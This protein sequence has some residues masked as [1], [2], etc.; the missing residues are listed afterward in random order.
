MKDISKSKD[1]KTSV[2]I[3]FYYV[4]EVGLLSKYRSMNLNFR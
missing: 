2:I 3:R 4:E 1:Q